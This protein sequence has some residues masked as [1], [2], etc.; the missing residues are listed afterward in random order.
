MKFKIVVDDDMA[1]I[2]MCDDCTSLDAFIDIYCDGDGIQSPIKNR[3][4]AKTLAEVIVKMLKVMCNDT[5]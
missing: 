5:E 2:C 1:S 4:D 3:E